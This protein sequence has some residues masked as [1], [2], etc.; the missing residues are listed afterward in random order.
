MRQ[1][2]SVPFVILVALGLATPALASD[3]PVLAKD[4]HIIKVT[5]TGFDPASIT[6]AKGDIVRWELQDGSSAHTIVSGTYQDDPAISD[7]RPR[8]RRQTR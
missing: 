6:V 2:R 4:P 3:G 8:L 7:R 1:W 5:D